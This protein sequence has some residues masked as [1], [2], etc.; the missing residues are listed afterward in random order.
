MFDRPLNA[1]ERLLPF[2]FIAVF[3]MR[4]ILGGMTGL[5][6]DEAYYWDWS[7]QLQLSYYDH[8]GMIAWLIK[9]STSIFGDTAF[10]VRLP[11]IL[12]N[13]GATLFLFLLAADMFNLRVAL[14]AALLHT[15]LPIFALGGMMAVPDAPM[16]FM[17]AFTAWLGWKI[18]SKVAGG[19]FLG[20]DDR[21]SPVLWFFMG[22][23][24]AIGFLSKYTAIMVAG[25]IFLYFFFDSGLRRVLASS[26]FGTALMITVIGM[27]PVIIWNGQNEWGSFAFHFSERQGGG[28]GANFT[29]WLQFWVAQAAFFTPVILFLNIYAMFVALFRSSDARWRYLFW[30]SFPTLVLFTGQALFA[31][32][33]PHWPAPAHFMLL[34]ASAKLLEEGFGGREDFQR[35]ARRRFVGWTAALFIIPLFVLF[36][37]AVWSPVLPR[38]AQLV[39]PQADWD[40]KFDPTNDLYG[41][42]ELAVHLEK[43]RKDREENGTGRPYLASSRYQLVSQLAFATKETVYRLSPAKDHYTFMQTPEVIE[44]LQDKP[45]LFVSDNRFERDPRRDIAYYGVFSMCAELEPFIVKRNEVYARTFRIYDCR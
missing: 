27:M 35:S 15:V 36:H 41:W 44:A 25:S 20:T 5:G 39:A 42:D 11:A 40:P 26:G 2:F 45:M 6:D 16:G 4:L 24:I 1:F 23:A 34:I 33:K 9:A 3:I 32:F 28:G 12:C 18:A 14:Y 19:T 43:I 31:E 10:A 8:P 7:R 38:L 17:W 37:V 29:R 30:L 21:V 22:L 13:T